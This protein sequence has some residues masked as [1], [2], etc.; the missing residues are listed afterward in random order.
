MNDIPKEVFKKGKLSLKDLV[1][2]EVYSTVDR[3]YIISQGALEAMISGYTSIFSV[4]FGLFLGVAGILWGFWYQCTVEPTRRYYL[5]FAVVSSALA[6]LCLLV[7]IAGWYRAFSAKR[8]LYK[9][10]K[11]ISQ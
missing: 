10:A 7:C 2:T 5:T 9:E 3:K 6:G 8:K 11:L 1:Q 4:V